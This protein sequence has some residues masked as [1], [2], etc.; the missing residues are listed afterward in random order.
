MSHQRDIGGTV[1][2]IVPVCRKKFEGVVLG[3]VDCLMGR[4]ATLHRSLGTGALIRNQ[5]GPLFIHCIVRP[6]AETNE[7]DRHMTKQKIDV[8]DA[9][10]GEKTNVVRWVLGASLAGAVAVAVILL[11]IYT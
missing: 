2:A 1:P 11:L 3:R 7:R 6:A 5:T 9:R 4:R 8:V 10:Q